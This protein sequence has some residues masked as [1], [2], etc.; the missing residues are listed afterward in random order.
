MSSE[1]LFGGKKQVHLVILNI[2]SGGFP[3]PRPDWPWGWVCRK[4]MESCRENDKMG[5]K[6]DFDAPGVEILMMF[7]QRK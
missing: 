6:N 5:D 2:F 4:M 7:Q 1:I 3:P